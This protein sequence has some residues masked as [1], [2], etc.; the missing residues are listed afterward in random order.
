MI[1]FIRYSD[2]SVYQ[3]NKSS[4]EKVSSNSGSS[5]A[6]WGELIRDKFDQVRNRRREVKIMLIKAL[7]FVI[8]FLIVITDMFNYSLLVNIFTVHFSRQKQR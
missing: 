4:V 6:G 1:H 5:S 3:V 8:I 2:R 7:Y